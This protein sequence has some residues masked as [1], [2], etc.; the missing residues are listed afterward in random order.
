[1][2]IKRNIFT[3]FE[4]TRELWNDYYNGHDNEFTIEELARI[5]ELITGIKQ[6]AEEI[7]EE[8]KNDVK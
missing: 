2:E 7:K 3:L 6:A 8:I 5:M 1:M 4:Y